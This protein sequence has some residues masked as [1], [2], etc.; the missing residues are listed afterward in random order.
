[1]FR[2]DRVEFMAIPLTA[3]ILG[4]LF[5]LFAVSG[6]GVWAWI[7][8]GVLMFGITCFVAWR[9]VEHHAHPPADDAPRPA[10]QRPPG[11][12]R[13]LVVVDESCPP[14]AVR[15]AIAQRTAGHTAEAFVVAPAA[16]SRLDRLMGDEAGY[17]NA[18]RHLETTMLELATVHDLAVRDG[19]VGSHD[20]I[21][22]ADECLREFPAD[23]IVFA[24]DPEGSTTWVEDGAVELA[25]SRYGIPVA[26][27]LAAP[28]ERL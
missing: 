2:S 3:V 7:A 21:Q 28:T 12:H 25:R 22:A 9:S 5:I 11:A 26:Q 20:P 4:V 19:K 27:L 8:T 6:V 18:A 1:V 23:E 14:E 15:D 13:V 10:A 24:V 17:Q 16:G